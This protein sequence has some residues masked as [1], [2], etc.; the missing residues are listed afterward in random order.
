MWQCLYVKLS[1]FPYLRESAV[2]QCAGHVPGMQEA[3]QFERRH[4]FASG[5]S[6]VPLLG[7][8]ICCPNEPA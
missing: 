4:F 1:S 8:S 7:S 2:Q 6:G 5:F 3:V